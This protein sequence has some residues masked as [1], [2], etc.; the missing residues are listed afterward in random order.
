MT[1]AKSAAY[2][3]SR[4]RRRGIDVVFSGG[5]CVSIDCRGKYVSADLDFIDSRFAPGRELKRAMFKIGF[6]EQDRYYIYPYAT[7]L[8]EFPASPLAARNEPAGRVLQPERVPCLA[9]NMV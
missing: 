7:P 9:D 4:S 1:V 8:F 6:G 2:V 5:S 3:A